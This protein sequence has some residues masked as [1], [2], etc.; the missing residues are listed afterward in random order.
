MIDFARLTDEDRALL[1]DVAWRIATD[2]DDRAVN[3]SLRCL[4]CDSEVRSGRLEDVSLLGHRP[5]CAFLALR[6][7]LGLPADDV[8]RP[9]AWGVW[10]DG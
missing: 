1:S 10:S 8:P 2:D 5:H 4:W 6:R 7:L 9:G 3:G